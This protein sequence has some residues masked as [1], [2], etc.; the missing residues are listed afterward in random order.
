MSESRGSGAGVI[1]TATVALLD[2]TL[3]SEL[4]K[5]AVTVLLPALTPVASPVVLTETTEG[6]LEVHLI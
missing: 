6:L 2:T 5:T 4:V 3:P 1:E